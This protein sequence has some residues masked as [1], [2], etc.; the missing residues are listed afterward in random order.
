MDKKTLVLA[1][2]LMKRIRQAVTR[3]SHI[4]SLR[5]DNPVVETDPVCWKKLKSYG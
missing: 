4:A 1:I 3:A 5:D 2:E